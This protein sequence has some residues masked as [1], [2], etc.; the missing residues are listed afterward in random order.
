MACPVLITSVD[1]LDNPAKFT[2]PLQFEIQYECIL[3]LNDGA[4]LPVGCRRLDEQLQ[5]WTLGSVLCQCHC[6]GRR[7]NEALP[8][9][10]ICSSAATQERVRRMLLNGFA[11]FVAFGC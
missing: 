6:A 9:F 3:P 8:F 2:N 5:L 10:A 7:A 11:S 4:C 1:V